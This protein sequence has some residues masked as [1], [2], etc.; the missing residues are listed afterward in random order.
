MT[1]TSKP[2]VTEDSESCIEAA[3]ENHVALVYVADPVPASRPRVSKW[4]TY[5]SGKYK[6]YLRHS[7][8]ALP[9]AA[10]PLEGDLELDLEFV[11]VRPK[12]TKRSNPRGDIDNYAKAIMDTITKLG[13]WNDDDQVVTATMHKRFAEAE[14]VP[15]TRVTINGIS[16]SKT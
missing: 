8:A 4:G 7:Q 11:A 1:T 9:K 12:T 15:H 10:F 3:D 5:Y 2:L 6:E 13:Y 14:E 16:E